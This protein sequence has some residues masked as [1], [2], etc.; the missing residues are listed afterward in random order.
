MKENNLTVISAIGILGML[1]ILILCVVG[2]YYFTMHKQTKDRLLKLS[3]GELRTSIAVAYGAADPKS[4]R[5]PSDLKALFPA[6][7]M[8]GDGYTPALNVR[9]VHSELKESDF[10]D[11]GG[12]V[13]STK[14]G[15][16]RP[17]LTQKHDY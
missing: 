2:P 6:E 13:Y 17:N 3:L 1:V 8:P 10:T 16:I 14:T 4:P 9:Y 11:T 5:F 12:W 7:K 15:E